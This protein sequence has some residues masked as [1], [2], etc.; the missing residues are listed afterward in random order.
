MRWFFLT[1][2]AFLIAY[3]LVGSVF[4]HLLF[5][6]PKVQETYFP[7]SGDTIVNAEQ[8]QRMVLRQTAH[9]TDGELVQVEVFLKPGGG[10]DAHVHLG[11]D[12]KL[13]VRAGELTVLMNDEEH[14][15]GVGD[16]LVVPAGKS[17]KPTNQGTRDA[18]VVLEMRPAGNYDQFLVQYHGFMTEEGA[19]RSDKDVFWQMVLFGP[20][21]HTFAGNTPVVLQRAVSFLLAPTARFL[22]YQSFYPEYTVGARK[23]GKAG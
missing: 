23:T 21:Y 1:V 6:E 14:R 20:R 5:S 10:P 9:E 15:L 12:A 22:G 16:T 4:H 17:H 11:Q 13:T 18:R 19:V 3:L 7:R 2:L 8:G